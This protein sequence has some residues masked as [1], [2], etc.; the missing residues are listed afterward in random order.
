MSII[1]FDG[2]DEVSPFSIFLDS[3][4]EHLG[5]LGWVM[6]IHSTTDC[7]VHTYI[8]F[9]SNFDQGFDPFLRVS[10]ASLTPRVSV[11]VLDT[12][13]NDVNLRTQVAWQKEITEVL[14]QPEERDSRRY[15][16][17]T[18]LRRQRPCFPNIRTGVPADVSGAINILLLRVMPNF[19]TP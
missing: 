14:A 5:D 2:E 19:C 6:P 4:F 18:I 3:L 15:Y 10:Y 17:C 8:I 13:R 9:G 12:G 16:A 11:V 1:G 7:R